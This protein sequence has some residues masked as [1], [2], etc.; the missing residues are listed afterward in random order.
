MDLEAESGDQ[1]DGDMEPDLFSLLV[2]DEENEDQEFELAPP[3]LEAEDAAR[4]SGLGGGSAPRGHVIIPVP[5]QPAFVGHPYT[6]LRLAQDLLAVGIKGNVPESTQEKYF[7]VMQQHLP[8][9]HNF[10]SFYQAVKMVQ[11]SATTALLEYPA[12]HNDCEVS[13]LTVEE[14][15]R[16]GQLDS[17]RCGSCQELLKHPMNGLKVRTTNCDKLSFFVTIVTGYLIH[18]SSPFA[19]V[20]F[21]Q[22]RNSSGQVSRRL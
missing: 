15:R 4:S 12:C 19:F 17:V 7:K 6:T 13:H 11:K 1:P 22:S 8:V 20:V 21:L 5:S 2:D 9:G 10:P 3:T 18:V 14:L 16:L